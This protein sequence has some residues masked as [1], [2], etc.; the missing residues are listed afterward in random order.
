MDF[1][2]YIFSSPRKARYLNKNVSAKE[3]FYGI[4]NPDFEKRQIKIIEFEDNKNLLNKIL[5]I[6]DKLITKF[7]SLPF[8]TSKLTNKKNFEIIKNSSDIFLINENV[9]CSAILLL[10]FGKS[11]NCKVYLFVMGLY[12]KKIRFKFFSKLHFYLIK[13]VVKRIDYV[14]FLGKGEFNKA[15]NLHK[16]FR[17]KF[18]YFPFSIDTYFWGTNTKSI[19]LENNDY[20]LFVGN[21]GNRD[22]VLLKK[23]ASKLP[24]YNFKIIS[25]IPELKNLNLPNVSL[26]SGN[27]SQNT[28]SDIELR[29]IYQNARLTVIPLKESSQPSGQSVALQSMAVGVPVMISSTSGFW[30]EDEFINN[31]HI[32]LQTNNNSQS[33][34]N[35]I[36]LIYHDIEKLNKVAREAKNL[37]NSKFDLNNFYQIMKLYL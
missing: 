12:S 31:K 10:L 9:G 20:I 22:P 24:D 21:D 35:N 11:K 33:W 2:T 28:L 8:Y 4:F 5:S 1:V 32:F 34:S 17:N 3:F 29:E 36:K 23:I 27:W 15:R 18:V 6:F 26:I 37:V 25:K 30:D 13:T 14:F 16:Q 19:E 7:I